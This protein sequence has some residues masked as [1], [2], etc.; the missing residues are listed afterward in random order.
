MMRN[1]FIGLCCLG[2][3]CQTQAVAA[4]Q[5]NNSGKKPAVVAKQPT[6]PQKEYTARNF[7]HLIGMK[8]FSEKA[9]TM[10]FKLYEGYVKNVNALIEKLKALSASG[11]DK[12]PEYAGLKRMFGWEFDGMRLHEYYFGFLGGDGKPVRESDLVKALEAQY[13]SY[14]KWKEDFVATGMIRGIGWAILYYDRQTGRLINSWINEHNLGHLAG[15]APILA[16]DVFEHAYIPDFGLERGQ[17]IQAY[18]DNLNWKA[19]SDHYNKVVAQS[20]E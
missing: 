8:G 15:G 1:V 3:V 16:M 7:Q 5:S 18:F 13:G 14:D 10:H 2:V 9:L 6:A 17:Y 20:A 11:Q 4:N 12:T 19:V